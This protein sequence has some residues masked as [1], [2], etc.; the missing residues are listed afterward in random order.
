MVTFL[1]FGEASFETTLAKPNI[2]LILADDLGFGEVGF[3]GGVYE[4]SKQWPLRAGKGS[5]YEGGV[6][7]P[8]IIR[9][10]SQIVESQVIDTPVTGL[11]LFPT[12]AT[13]A[14]ASMPENKVL[15]GV[16]LSSLLKGGSIQARTLFWNFPI[17]LQKG[18]KETVDVAFRTRPGSTMRKDNWKLHEHFEDGKVELYNLEEDLGEKKDLSKVHPELVQELLAELSAWRTSLGAPVPSEL[19]DDYEEK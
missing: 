2:I 4:N 17:Y 15:D 16:D 11:D 8:L 5:Y 1:Y 12:F 7:V 14:G 13:V 9:W 3:N 10:P 19:N 18:N 6:R